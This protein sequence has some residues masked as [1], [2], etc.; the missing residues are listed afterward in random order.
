M[1]SQT[2]CRLLSKRTQ[3][4]N[5][6][7]LPSFGGRPRIAAYNAN[8]RHSNLLRANSLVSQ[9]PTISGY[10]KGLRRIAPEGVA[11]LEAAPNDDE[12]AHAFGEPPRRQAIVNV[13]GAIPASRRRSPKAC[14]HLYIPTE[15]LDRGWA[16][17]CMRATR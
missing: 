17:I 16:T 13:D 9:V 2:L 4:N 7:F 14:R 10:Q 1:L 12:R 8:L 11:A 6:A 15:K 5:V 3:A